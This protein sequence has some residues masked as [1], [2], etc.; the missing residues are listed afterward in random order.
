MVMSIRCGHCGN[1]HESVAAVRRCGRG[2]LASTRVATGQPVRVARP[3]VATVGLYRKLGQIY[4]V[5]YLG[6]SGRLVARRLDRY[7]D[8][9]GQTAYRLATAPGMATRLTQADRMDRD[10]AAEFGRLTWT[11]IRCARPLKLPESR[12]RGM[13]RTC[14]EKI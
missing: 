1:K 5:D 2:Q 9:D 13:G 7:V 6:G 12:A 8:S 10:E 14:W 3:P 4:A 11:C